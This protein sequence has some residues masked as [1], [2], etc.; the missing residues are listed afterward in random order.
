MEPTFLHKFD[1][2]FISLLK[3]C[4]MKITGLVKVLW[5]SVILTSHWC[6]H[7]PVNVEHVRN[8]SDS[9]SL[10]SVISLSGVKIFV[11]INRILIELL[12][13]KLGMLITVYSF[14]RGLANI[15]IFWIFRNNTVFTILFSITSPNDWHVTH[16]NYPYSVL[17]QCWLN[18][19][20]NLSEELH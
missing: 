17:M 18:I 12:H 20:S 11:Y 2:F 5:L 10:H 7:Y 19:M 6:R 1:Q 16:T 15:S 9:I 4:M 3:S 8:Y 14:A 13:W